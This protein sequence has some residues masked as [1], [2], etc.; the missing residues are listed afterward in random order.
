MA[1]TSPA[2]FS[3]LST[4]SSRISGLA[5]GMDIDS[6]IEKL[7]KAESAK[8]EKLQQQKQKYEWQRDSYRSVNTKLEAFR[9]ESFNKYSMPSNFLAKTATSSDSSKVGVTATSSATGNLTISSVS[10][11]ASA[12]SVKGTGITDK[13]GLAASK[14]TTIGDLNGASSTGTSILKLNIYKNTGDKKLTPVEIEYSS[15]DTLEVIA[16]KINSKGGLTAV[17]GTNGAFSITSNATGNYSGGSIQLVEDTDG[18]LNKLNITGTGSNL[19]NGINAEYTLNDVKMESQKNSFTELGYNISLKSTFN[20]ATPAVTITSSLNTDSI[21]DTVKSFVELYNGLVDSISPQ[22]KEKKNYNYSP[23]TN[24]QK[25]EMSEDEIEKWETQAKQGL[26]RNDES[27]TKVLSEMRSS[28]Y[29]VTSNKDSKYNTLFN[30]GI[31]TSSTYTDGGKL[32]IDEDKLRAAIEANP[33]A[34]ADLFT[35]SAK[36]NGGS[37]KGGLIDQ[38]RSIAKV[39]IDSIA[40]KAGKQDSIEGTF[41]LGKNIASL[42]ER[43]ESWA[44][45]LKDIENRYF[46]QFSAME[47]AI[48]KANSQSSLFA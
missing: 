34:V 13:N 32:E 36:A 27:I 16:K 8:M 31:T 43:I 2:S 46:T 17:V 33:E 39:G 5:S 12:G 44:D 45:K 3:Y 30:I 38:V 10:K 25:V 14:S 41:S 11:L 7:M 24:A 40:L 47:T 6:I 28:I 35:R 26:L 20:E 15:T 4:S 1:S 18:L 21:V 19:A 48:Q 29:S 23:L 42:T 9:T 37:D 22:T